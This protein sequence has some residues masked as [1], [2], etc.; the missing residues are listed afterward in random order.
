[1]VECGTVISLS[2]IARAKTV[3]IPSIF[4]G[5]SAD[6]YANTNGDLYVN[7]IGENYANKN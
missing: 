3:T 4:S 2:W 7:T 5:E 1:M 6:I